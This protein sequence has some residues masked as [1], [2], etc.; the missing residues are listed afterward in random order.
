[1]THQSVFRNILKGSSKSLAQH[2]ERE[3]WQSCC[4]P[5]HIM[6][7][8]YQQKL[9][10]CEASLF[11]RVCLSLLEPLSAALQQAS[12]PG[13]LGL[14]CPSFKAT[15]KISLGPSKMNHKS[16]QWLLLCYISH[17]SP[18]ALLTDGHYWPAIG[19]RMLNWADLLWQCI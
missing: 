16:S 10:M 17:F 12:T 9:Q 4:I 3:I 6:P 8:Q 7:Y 13:R 19:T 5:A 14:H 11:L 15:A 18:L 1:M 2:T